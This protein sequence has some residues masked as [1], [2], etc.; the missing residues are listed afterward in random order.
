MIYQTDTST[1]LHNQ[2]DITAT[3]NTTHDDQM[4]GE[5]FEMSLADPP[6]PYT[7]RCNPIDPTSTIMPSGLLS[8]AS[9]HTP[10]SQTPNSIVDPAPTHAD[11]DGTVSVTCTQLAPR[12]LNISIAYVEPDESGFGQ[13]EPVIYD[14]VVKN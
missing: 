4:L 11:V 9:V 3:N 10:E 1:T 6:V 5:E 14:K 13:E 7:S 2:P 8:S 12:K